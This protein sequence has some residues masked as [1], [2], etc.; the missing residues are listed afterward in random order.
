MAA[1]DTLFPCG[2]LSLE[3]QWHMPPG[4]GRFPAVVVLH[5]HPLF[6]GG[7]SNNV[8][9]AVCQGLEEQGIAAFR[10]NFRGVGRS[11][12]YYGQGSSERL[13]AAA[14]L[15]FV[16]ADDRVHPDRLGLA[17][18]SFGAGVALHVAVRDERVRALALVSPWLK[19]D[20]S[21]LVEHWKHPRLLVWGDKD[22]YAP[23][24]R[25]FGGKRRGDRLV[26]AGADHLWVGKEDLLAEAVTTLFVTAFAEG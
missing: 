15:D 9:L 13:D 11:Q 10:F 12:G 17:G 7:M 24:A 1:D 19:P 16:S 14:A 8:V 4:E 25:E 2:D 23:D 22:E 3:G 5:P 26:I 6:G 18:Y 21:A 20:E